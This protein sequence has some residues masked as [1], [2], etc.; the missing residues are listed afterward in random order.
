MKK[1]QFAQKRFNKI[2]KEVS[3]KKKEHLKE[4]FGT[5]LNR[6]WKSTRHTDV[7]YRCKCDWCSRGKTANNRRTKIACEEQL[8]EFLGDEKEFAAVFYINPDVEEI[9]INC[10]YGGFSLSNEAA[11]LLADL[12]GDVPT[13]DPDVDRNNKN[14]VA[15]VKALGAKANGSYAKLRIV[16]L[17]LNCKWRITEYDGWERVELIPQLWIVLNKNVPVATVLASTPS[18]ARQI[19]AEKFSHNI[20]IKPVPDN[21]YIW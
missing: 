19:V 17:E 7:L 10:C 15:V 11:Q 8:K 2:I 6:F 16:E 14:L 4:E 1:N 13:N 18:E 5:E 12:T 9:V 20:L 3:K 21:Y